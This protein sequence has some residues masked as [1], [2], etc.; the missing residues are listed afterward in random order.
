MKQNALLWELTHEELKEVADM[1]RAALA[2]APDWSKALRPLYAVQATLA[3][4]EEERERR[5]AESYLIIS[6]GYW[7]RGKTLVEA[8]RQLM[9]ASGV[10]RYEADA[11]AGRVSIRCIT[12]DPAPWVDD[13]GMT[14]RHTAATMTEV[15]AS[16]PLVVDDLREV[17]EEL[18][19]M[20]GEVTMV[21]SR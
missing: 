4:L 12:G 13:Y 9:S 8:G 21:S 10:S 11:L 5:R 15:D 7:G 3:G 18:L 1:M 19:D 16:D 6:A 2:D 14:H 17:L 20:A